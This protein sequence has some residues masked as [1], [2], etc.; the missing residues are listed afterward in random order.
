MEQSPASRTSVFQ[1]ILQAIKNHPWRTL[2]VVFALLI[3]VQL[4]TLPLG[5]IERLR[6]E[7]PKETAFMKHHAEAARKQ[8]KPFRI[9]QRWVSLKQIPKATID[10]VIVAEDGTFWSHSGFDWFEFKESL[11]RNLKELRF[12]R[13]GSTITQQLVKNLYL[14][15]SKDPLRKLKEWILTWKMENTLSKSRILELYL[16]VIE[17]GNGIYG[18]EAAANDYFGKPASEL[19]RGESARL[20]AVIPNPKRYRADSDSRY[21][22]RRT[23]MILSRMEARSV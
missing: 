22:L 8:G 12:A 13:G 17:W 10:A 18:I 14:S 11:V 20:A 4:L 6:T 2:A 5:D 7:N 19:T 15:T 9:I 21:V 23:R 16:N 1:R 3:F